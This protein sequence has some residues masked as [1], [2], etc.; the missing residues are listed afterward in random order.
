M[1]RLTRA[2]QRAQQPVDEPITDATETTERSPLNEITPNASPEHVSQVEEVPKKTPA[3]SKSKKGGKKGAKA[4]KG[5]AVEEEQEQ[6]VLED[7]PQTAEDT[8]IEEVV[9]EEAPTPSEGKLSMIYALYT[10]TN[11]IDRCS[12]NS[13]Q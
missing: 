6:A 1:P 10:T 7:V 9:E 2:A 8:P 5:K 3:R 11:F 12:P 4:K 13:H